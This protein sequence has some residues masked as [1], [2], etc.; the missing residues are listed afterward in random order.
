[1][2]PTITLYARDLYSKWGFHDGDILQDAVHNLGLQGVRHKDVLCRLVEDKL[3]PALPYPVK[4]ER[5]DTCHNPIR[6][7]DRHQYDSSLAFNAGI[8]IDV[9]YDDIRRCADLE[10]HR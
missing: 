10:A 6:V 1:M 3:L 5:I 9:T 4:L 2:S 7:D 8:G